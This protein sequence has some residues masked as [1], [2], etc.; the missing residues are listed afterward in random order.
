M[1]IAR[2]LHVAAAALALGVSACAS[3]PPMVPRESFIDKV[4]V[5]LKETVTSPTIGGLVA[6]QTRREAS[7]FG[8][9]GAPKQLRIMVT[10]LH[11]KDALKSA[12]VGDANKL[13]AHVSVADASGRPQG[14]FDAVAL[15][16]VALNG[17]SGVL[18]AAMQDKSVVD[19]RLADGLAVEVMAKVYGSDAAAEASKRPIVEEAEPAPTAPSP[20]APERQ[21]APVKPKAAPAPSA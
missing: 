15:D 6:A 4:D 10:E 12:L 3:Y 9:S 14:E 19:Q 1:R 20:A 11:Y 16:Q 21:G 13:S 18:I 7:R 5:S 17:L 2:L 8:H